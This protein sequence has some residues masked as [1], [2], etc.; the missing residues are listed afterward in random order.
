[1]TAMRKSLRSIGKRKAPRRKGTADGI[2]P[3][4]L[5]RRVLS[6]LD[7]YVP[8]RSAEEIA[9]LYGIREVTK[10]GSN[11]N[12]L[13]VSARVRDAIVS[14]ID[15]I[16]HYPDPGAT[17]LRGRLASRFGI[18][19]E[20]LMVSNGADNVLTCVG[21]AFL[22]PGDRCIVGVPTYTAYASLATLMGATPVEVP[23]RDW[24]MDVRAMAAAA[25]G[26]KA[27]FICNPNNPTGTVLRHE[28]V[29]AF[30]KKAPADSLIVL[31]EAYAEWVEDPAFPDA[32][33]L[34]RHHAN[35]IVLRTFSKIYGLAGLRV[36]YAVAAP[37]LIAYLNQV[38][39]PFPV[40]RLAQA[41]AEAILDDTAYTQAAF[42]NNRRGKAFLTRAFT[43]MGLRHLPSQANFLFVDLGR[44][45]D[46]IAER[47]LEQGVIV[48]PGRLWRLPTWTRI[49]IGT[50]AD[51]ARLVDALRGVLRMSERPDPRE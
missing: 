17:R 33:A 39:E 8:G 5:A 35:L 42:E 48:R 12:P 40:S 7:P 43:E 13:G 36:G 38:R 11:E 22:D 2:R 19:P 21:L 26:A 24:R 30:L 16:H 9:E 44:P 47:L 27:V 4:P 28:E 50:P 18:T 23:L 49:T 20:H 25:A 6:A 37:E 10:L 32:I 31:D 46:Q 41:A 15:R 51:N 29:E 3:H 45:A 1:M 34:L 14:A